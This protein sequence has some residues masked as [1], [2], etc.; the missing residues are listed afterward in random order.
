MEEKKDYIEEWKEAY[1]KRYTDNIDK[2]NYFTVFD[3]W[4]HVNF[5]Y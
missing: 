2:Y 1:R 5:N 3:P 4:E